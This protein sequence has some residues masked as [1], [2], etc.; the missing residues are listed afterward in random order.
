MAAHEKPGAKAAIVS[1]TLIQQLATVLPKSVTFKIYHL[2]TPPTKTSALYFPPPGTR[3]DRTYC[4]SH[5]LTASIRT[6]SKD[7]A[8]DTVEVL[9][10]AV[11]ILIYSTAYDSTFFVS[12]ADSTGYLN[13]LGFA[14]GTPSPIRDIT[15]TFL[16]HLVKQHQRKT[17]EVSSPSSQEHKTNISFPGA[18]NTRANMSYLI[19]G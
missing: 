5:F 4:E 3:P 12:K 16:W 1:P 13:L 11:E 8:S 19:E 6:S 15:A 10:F 17:Y 14:K 2:S 18:S 9:V 7:N